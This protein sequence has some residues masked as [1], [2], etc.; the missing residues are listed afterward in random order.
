MVSESIPEHER[1]SLT[2]PE[3]CR[4]VEQKQDRQKPARLSG[5]HIHPIGADL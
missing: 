2:Y 3:L 5:N 4:L 1:V